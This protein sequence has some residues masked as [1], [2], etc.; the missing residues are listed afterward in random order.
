MDESQLIEYST[1]LSHEV[2][3]INMLCSTREYH[4]GMGTA[5]QNW[6]DFGF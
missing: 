4:S 2:Y 6:C 5:I 1:Y 3:N